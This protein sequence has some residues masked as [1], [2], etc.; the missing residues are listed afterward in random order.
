MAESSQAIIFYPYTL[1]SVERI[2]KFSLV[3]SWRMKREREPKRQSKML[4][5]LSKDIN[6]AMNYSVMTTR[7]VIKKK[8]LLTSALCSEGAE[9]S[10]GTDARTPLKINMTNWQIICS[11]RI[12]EQVRR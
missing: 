6:V 2:I 11:I 12:A 9:Q 4:E 1:L 8:A 5:M 10:R 7:S 3:R